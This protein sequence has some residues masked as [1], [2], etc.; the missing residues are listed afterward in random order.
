MKVLIGCDVDPVLPPLLREPPRE[1]VWECLGNLEG[2]LKAATG[3]L[4]PVTWLIR[5]DDSIRFAT[6]DFAS[7][8]RARKSLWQTLIGS[9]HE[10]GWHVHLMSFDAR[11]GCFGFD[12]G[13]TW[14]SDACRALAEH[15]DVRST[16]TGWDY[17]DNALFR[18]FDA[19]GVTTDFSA[20]P[21]NMAW[22]AAGSDR[23]VVDW[24]RCPS[25][26]YH[27]SPDDYQRPGKLNLLEIPITQFP[28]SVI[29]IAKRIAKRLKHGSGCMSGLRNRTKML[30]DRWD[31]VPLSGCTIS[32]F[33]F[34]PEDLR[35]SGVENMLR[36]LER[37]RALPDAEFVTASAAR[38][39]LVRD[40]AR[41]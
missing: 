24:L 23:L 12:P 14:L 21:G 28:D 32:A 15:Y 16:R 41:A 36:N 10:L 7:G 35:G 40:K 39:F 29:G 19:L 20:L 17:A 5:A 38:Q 2:L 8:Y 30:T 25:H 27:P 18:R 34:H 4:P 11:R 13:A 22:H 26:P 33:Y 31:C 1:D 3:G 6:G 37:L 9:G